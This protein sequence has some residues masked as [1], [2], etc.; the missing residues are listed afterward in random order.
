[1]SREIK[2]RAWNGF[3]M[4]S[5]DFCLTKEGEPF[6]FGTELMGEIKVDIPI[7]YGKADLELM[8]FTGLKDKNGKEIYEGDLIEYRIHPQ[9]PAEVYYDERDCGFRLRVNGEMQH[10]KTYPMM[11]AQEVIGNIYEN[12]KLLEGKP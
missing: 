2:F 12:P 4:I 9:Y 5:G 1:M 3:T 7:P 11:F 8:Q 10:D 6:Y